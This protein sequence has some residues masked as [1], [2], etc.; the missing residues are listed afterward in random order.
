[1]PTYRFEEI[2]RSRTV[3]F[4]CECRRR[5]QRTV[6]ASQTI[7]PFNKNVDG[8][9]KTRGEI[10]AE[11]GEQIAAKRPDSTCKC[12]QQADEVCPNAGAAA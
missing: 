8:Q 2:K 11:L 12:G 5:F 4:K 7:N 9:P 1:M 6:S 10:W 3:K